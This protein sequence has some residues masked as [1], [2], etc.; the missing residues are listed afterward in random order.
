[1]TY[2]ENVS[3]PVPLMLDLHIDHD[4][5]G[6]NSDPSL[7]GQLHYSNDINK[8]LSESTADKIRKYLADY[9]N[10]PPTVFSDTLKV[11][12]VSTLSKTTVLR[13]NINIDGTPITSKHILTH[14]IR[15]HLVY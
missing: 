12:V 8:S 3:G 2:L 10:N 1:V 6:S 14:H 9:N 5:F 13:I 15:K 11:K 7:N 4:R